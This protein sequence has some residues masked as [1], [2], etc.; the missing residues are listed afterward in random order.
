[1][2]CIAVL[3]CGGLV[4]L[5]ITA[6]AG[7][8]ISKVVWRDQCSHLGAA[9]VASWISRA[10]FKHPVCILSPCPDTVCL[11]AQREVKQSLVAATCISSAIGCFLMAFLANMPLIVA[12]GMGINAYFT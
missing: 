4:A 9:A 12:P 5:L 8:M 3:L 11:A 7:Q 10:L 1:M 6:A 2:L